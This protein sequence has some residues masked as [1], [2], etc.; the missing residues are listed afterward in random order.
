MINL[1]HSID[2]KVVAEGV[3]N[4]SQFAYLGHS[5]CDHIQGY[6]LGRPLSPQLMMSLLI[7]QMDATP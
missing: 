2:L 1:A 5:G 4:E 6:L 3:E 7:S